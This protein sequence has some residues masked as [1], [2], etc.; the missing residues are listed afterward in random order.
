MLK[1]G[2][3]LLPCHILNF[4]F[5][6]YLSFIFLPA[7]GPPTPRKCGQQMCEQL[8]LQVLLIIILL[9]GVLMRSLFFSPFRPQQAYLSLLVLDVYTLVPTAPVVSDSTQAPNYLVDDL[10]NWISTPVST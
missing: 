9:P 5:S 3:A 8:H 7:A 6:I 2:T 1:M 4:H 10:L